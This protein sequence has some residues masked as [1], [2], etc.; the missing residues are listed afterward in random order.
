MFNLIG[1]I[2]IGIIVGLLGLNRKWLTLGG[3]ITLSIVSFF[4]FRCGGFIWFFPGVIVFLSGSVL[5][6]YRMKDKEKGQLF[7]QKGGVRDSFQV[8]ANGGIATLLAI[9]NYFIIKNDFMFFIYLGTLAS[10]NADNWATEIGMLSKTPPRLITNLKPTESGVSGAIT[11]LGTGAAILG[12]LVISV[13]GLSQVLLIELFTHKEHASIWPLAFISCFIGGIT[14]A[15]V[16]SFI[17]ATIQGQYYCPACNHQTEQ[18]I[19]RCGCKTNIIGGFRWLNNDVVN[20]F[21]TVT[22]AVV[23]YIV[24]V[25][26]S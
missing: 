11:A 5:T 2:I 10:A 19:H 6:K 18:Q 24:Y 3:A 4:I 16:D 8:I 21:C 26:V 23:T 17:G 14:G 9:V 7:F 22:G 1:G 15:F 20:L 25:L 12:S 13:I